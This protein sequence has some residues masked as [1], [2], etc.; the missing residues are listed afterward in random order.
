M[1]TQTDLKQ[2]NTDTVALLHAAEAALAEERSARHTAEAEKEVHSL[3]RQLHEEKSGRQS[4]EVQRTLQDLMV[5]PPPP[6]GGHTPTSR[7]PCGV[8]V[9]R[10]AAGGR[11]CTTPVCA[12]AISSRSKGCPGLHPSQRLQAIPYNRLQAPPPPSAAR[13]RAGGPSAVV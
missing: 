8:C 9:E 13:K 7:S 6:G 4:A 3:Q 1:Q 2:K 10:L 5:W 12:R 11:M